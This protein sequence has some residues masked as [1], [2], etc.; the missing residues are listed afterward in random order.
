ML[1]LHKIY[2]DSALLVINRTLLNSINALLVLSKIY[3]LVLVH[4]IVRGSCDNQCVYCASFEHVLS[5]I[6][7]GQTGNE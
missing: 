3:M 6:F 5:E 7:M 1:S 2:G 4:V